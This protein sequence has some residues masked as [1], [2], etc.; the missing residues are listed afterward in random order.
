MKINHLSVPTWN[1]CNVNEV[2]VPLSSVLPF[3][4]T[5]DLPS[6]VLTEASNEPCKISTGCGEEF[7]H[8]L[9]NLPK[10]VFTVSKK[11]SSALRL[12]FDFKKSTS[13]SRIQV[14]TLPNSELEVVMNYSSSDS[15]TGAV[16]VE[17]MADDNSK[18][19][20]VQVVDA[21]KNSVLIN[22][23]GMTISTN[24]KVTLTQVYL[25]GAK[26]YGGAHAELLGEGAKFDCNTG[27]NLKD[28]QLLD[29]NLVAIHRGKKSVSDIKVRGTLSDKSE[30][31]YRGTID[32][33]TG[34]SGSKG[35]ESE[36]ALLLDETVASKAV[37]LI[38]CTEDDV[39][40]AHG[41]SIGRLDEKVEYYLKS[42][43]LSEK[44]IRKLMA[45]AKIEATIKNVR[46]KMALDRIRELI[47]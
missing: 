8:A 9:Q 20:L 38:L 21:G 47:K 6:G 17:I 23:I 39:E 30:K 26:M 4:P 42:R 32:F 2:E 41:A 46:D 25:N 1:K 11:C 36:E 37:P 13:G 7:S 10:Q 28:S 34:A 3:E 14:H 33:K 43:G 12:D 40:G 24:A 27:Y 15:G 18:I 5:A 44:Q 19:N 35:A 29:L 16:Q 31:T 45:K 22:D